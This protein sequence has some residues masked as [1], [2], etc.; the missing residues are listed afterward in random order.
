MSASSSSPASTSTTPHIPFINLPPPPLI[1]AA[2]QPPPQSCRAPTR[3]VAGSHARHART[4]AP[5]TAVLLRRW[6]SLLG[7]WTKMARLW[8][9]LSVVA[10]AGVTN[11]GGMDRSSNERHLAPT[12]CPSKTKASMCDSPGRQQ[13]RQAFPPL[14]GRPQRHC[15]LLW[16]PLKSEAV[17]NNRGGRRRRWH[18]RGCA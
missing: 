4:R 7:G 2:P 5:P 18:L 1:S 12:G 16:D 8:R 11:D 17:R 3:P 13:Y 15:Q 14:C 6:L 10:M 9:C